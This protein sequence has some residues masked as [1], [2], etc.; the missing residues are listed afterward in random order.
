MKTYRIKNKFRFIT[1]VTILIIM[2]SMLL[3]IMFPI[4]AQSE[5]SGKAY[6]EVCVNNGDTLWDLAKEYGS[7]DKDIRE[8]IYEICDIN[9]I[10]ASEL[11]AGLNI[12]IPQ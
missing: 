10:S 3:G 11:T 6:V 12:I 9:G 4:T 8:I 2:I 1:F 7:P 5:S